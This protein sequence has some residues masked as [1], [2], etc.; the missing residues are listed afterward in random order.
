M[1]EEAQDLGEKE[2][3]RKDDEAYWTGIQKDR[4]EAKAIE[5][6]VDEAY[7]ANIKNGADKK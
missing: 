1:A 7:W 5:R 4:T 6:A 3:E 2:E